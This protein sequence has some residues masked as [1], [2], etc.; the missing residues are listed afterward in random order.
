MEENMIYAFFIQKNGKSSVH[1]PTDDP[2][3]S[4]LG[5][6][7]HVENKRWCHQGNIHKI[8]EVCVNSDN[9]CVHAVLDMSKVDHVKKLIDAIANLS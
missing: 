3:L 1:L 8:G 4:E 7:V 2:G 5:I 9:S 6:T